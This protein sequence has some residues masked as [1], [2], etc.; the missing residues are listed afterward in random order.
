MSLVADALQPEMVRGL[1]ALRGRALVAN[2]PDMIT[3]SRKSGFYLDFPTL[4]TFVSTFVTPALSPMRSEGM[5][6]A[7][8]LRRSYRYMICKK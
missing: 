2:L 4:V 1:F 5:H 8:Q 7:S 3:G 6:V